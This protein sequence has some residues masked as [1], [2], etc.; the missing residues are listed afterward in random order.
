M[1][2]QNSLPPVRILLVGDS[3]VALKNG[4]GPGFCARAASEVQCINLA[5]NGR[6]SGSYRA[7]GLWD[8]VMEELR[9]PAG[10]TW[11]LIQF[12]HN[13]QPGKPGRSTD[14]RTEFPANLRRYVE[15]ARAAGAN[16]VLITPLTRR[17]F[18]NGKVADDLGP[19]A[20]AARRVAREAG[21]PLLELNADSLA[22]V[23]AMGGREAN[24]LAMAPPPQVVD[25]GDPDNS[26]SAPKPAPNTAEPNGETPPVFD[27][28][29]LGPKGSAFFGAMV[30]GELTAAVPELNPYLKPLR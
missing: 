9:R 11:V 19:W 24:T 14:L 1:A 23:Q 28:T 25:A 16:P 3:T 22:A 6:S 30:W 10:K 12:G 15:E 26:V 2:G 20:D 29:H 7:E 17:T 27:Y 18:R 8:G 4:W 13:D 5:R 21:V